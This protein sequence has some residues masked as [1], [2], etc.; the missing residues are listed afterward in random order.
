[1]DSLLERVVVDP[2]VCHGQAR[3]RGT[4]VMVWQILAYLAN[5]DSLEEVLDAHP[6][7]TREDA[8]ACLEYAAQAARERIVPIEIAR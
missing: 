2:D 5:G 1:M 3:I 6:G 7:L 4:R 8:L